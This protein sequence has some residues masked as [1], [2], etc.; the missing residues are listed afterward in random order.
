MSSEG[1]SCFDSDTTGG[2]SCYG[3]AVAISS[4]LLDQLTE[5][6]H[7]AKNIMA[8]RCM[9]SAP[10]RVLSYLH[11][12][13]APGQTTCVLNCPIKAIAEQICCA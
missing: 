9:R 13:K 12:L 8:L 11:N 10:D 4:S 7:I 1:A 2:W 6:L 3:S 5:Q